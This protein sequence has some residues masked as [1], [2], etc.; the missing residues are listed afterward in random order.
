MS[1]SLRA[2]HLIGRL[3]FPKSRLPGAHPSGE[4]QKQGTDRSY[5]YSAVERAYLARYDSAERAWLGLGYPQLGASLARRRATP[6]C[7]PQLR[8]GHSRLG[9]PVCVMA[10]EGPRSSRA[11]KSSR[12][13]NKT[14]RE[15]QGVSSQRLDLSTE[16]CGCR[17]SACRRLAPPPGRRAGGR[18]KTI[19]LWGPKG[20]ID[21]VHHKLQLYHWNLADRHLVSPQSGT[22]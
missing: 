6:V 19:R 14:V 18:E 9:G 4:T 16:N 1:V 10:E 22:A 8:A 13:R 21:K 2:D 11:Q 17:H 15:I 3:L 12:A 7:P 20:F 5:S